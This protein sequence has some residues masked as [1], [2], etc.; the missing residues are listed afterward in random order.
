M[1]VAVPTFAKTEI[2][3]L[4]NGDFEVT[5]IYDGDLDAAE[6]FVGGKMNDWKA[7]HPDWKMEKKDG[8]WKLTKELKPGEYP[9]KFVVNGSDWVKDNDAEK[10][11]PDGFGGQNSV[12]VAIANNIEG[13]FETTGSLT[14]TF[15]H[16]KDDDY[17]VNFDNQLLLEV[18]GTAAESKGEEEIDRVK[19]SGKVNLESNIA[20]IEDVNEMEILSIDTAELETLD[21]TYLGNYLNINAQAYTEHFPD[22]YDYLGILSGEEEKDN[23]VAPNEM[24]DVR[25]LKFTANKGLDAQL[26]INEYEDRKYLAYMNA[27]K[28]LKEVIGHDLTIGSSG[29][30]YQPKLMDSEEFNDR[31]YYGAVFSEYKPMEGLSLKG[32]YA[33][34]PTGDIDQNSY[35][36]EDNGDGS[37]TVTF[38]LESAISSEDDFEDMEADDY[39]RVI[40]FGEMNDD[41]TEEVV[42]EDYRYELEDVEDNKWEITVSADEL[43][44]NKWKVVAITED[45]EFHYAPSGHGDEKNLS[46]WAD[47][48]GEIKPL[49]DGNAYL[50]EAKYKFIDQEASMKARVKAGDYSITKYKGEVTAGVKGVSDEAYL[51]V[52]N[53]DFADVPEGGKH[54]AYVK[55]DYDVLDGL[56]LDGEVLYK[57]AREDHEEENDDGEMETTTE[58]GDVMNQKVKAGFDWSEPVPGLDNVKGH[59]KVDPEDT[60][61][62]DGEVQ[63]LFAEAT[64]SVVP[65]VKTLKANT[66]QRL[67]SEVNEYYGET[68]LDIPLK[69]IDYIKGDVLYADDEVNFEGNSGLVEDAGLKY[70]ASGKIHQLPVIKDYLTH[71]EVEYTSDEDGII[72]HE[73]Y[74]DEDDND[75]K[76]QVSAETKLM[77]PE[78]NNLVDTFKWDGI[79]ITGDMQQVED[80]A[81]DISG[82]D[83][84]F[85][86]NYVVE[87]DKVEWYMITTFETGF[88]LPFDIRNDL[89]VKY[90]LNHGE[91]S[92]YEDDALL[93]EFSKEVNMRTEITASYNKQ[94]ED[95]GEDYSKVMVETTF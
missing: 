8:V 53:D 21:V 83:D 17:K 12:V 63:E 6:V 30:I 37:Y 85:N 46:D 1:A 90:D 5:W 69:Q 78:I 4:D 7:S 43:K 82:L 11:V 62:F 19:Y 26:S 87:G 72:E 41:W 14:H 81:Y 79:T 32:E 64:T 57:I 39:E 44:N 55:G 49:D 2:K 47:A 61:D 42:G 45:D 80:D 89:T 67:D 86:G 48:T 13:E 28:N 58:Q 74:D 88:D 68:E 59:A 84:E 20:D 66:T 51:K 91:I 54:E 60:D 22:S 25:M 50:A 29:V 73:D 77:L 36:V 95:E 34:V 35:V 9:Y 71:V 40:L 10:F 33:Y 76:N 31:A 16:G 52:A 65:F 38:N 15:E 18:K 70:S 92:E 27:K 56:T 75:W 3:E 24:G 94:D 93:V 23:A